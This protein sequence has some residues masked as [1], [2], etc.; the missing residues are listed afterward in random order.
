MRPS[1]FLLP[2]LLAATALHAQE[3]PPADGGAKPDRQQ[4]SKAAAEKAFAEA[5]ANKDAKLDRA[6]FGTAIA[7][8]NA[9]RAER[10]KAANRP[11][12]P[13]ATAEQLDQAFA[14]A[15]ANADKALD[16]AEY[17]AAQQAMRPKRDKPADG[18]A[19][20]PAPAPAP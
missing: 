3:T 11:A 18:A 15:D 5:D 9:A 19:P 7:A 1:P 8:I 20:A 14:K 13:E 12:P 10:A 2:I 6:E 17:L 4:Q 16:S